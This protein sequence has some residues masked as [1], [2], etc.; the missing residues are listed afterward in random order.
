[1]SAQPSDLGRFHPVPE[2]L[3][4]AAVERAQHHES[5]CGGPIS[6][7]R[8][9]Q[10]LGF[11]PGAYT[12][13]NLR[14]LLGALV[15]AGALQHLRRFSRDHWALTSAGRRRVSRLRTREEQL[16]LPESPQHRLWRQQHTRA[17]EGMDEY[18]R[19]LREALEQAAAMIDDERVDSESWLT[20]TKRL[21]VRSEVFGSAI[22]CAREWAEPDD[23]ERDAEDQRTLEDRRRI[24]WHP[25][26]DV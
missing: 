25:D 4:L 8:I 1:M 23:G 2:N 17:V 18:C 15:Q 13:R 24:L 7:T 6:M 16:E 26:E 3:V 12:T 19:R 20:I 14:P 10:H 9:A 22:Y 21:K 5:R 11:A